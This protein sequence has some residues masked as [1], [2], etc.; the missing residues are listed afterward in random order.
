MSEPRPLA[1]RLARVAVRTL[2][3]L[4]APVQRVLAG[5]PVVVDGQTLDTQAQLGMRLL[6]L[7]V[8]ET[9]ERL[10][11]EQG[12][13]QISGEAWVFGCE[14]PVAEVR[15]TTLPGPAGP[16]PVR[17][18]RPAGLPATSA[19]LV[20]LHGG[21][22]VLGDLGSG[23]SVCRYLAGAAGLT[24]VSVDYRLAPEHP[25]PAALD[26][27]L[28]AFDAVHEGAADLGIDPAALGVGGES[29]GGNLAA[30][31]AIEA[32]RRA[33]ADASAAVPAL[34][35]LLMPVTDLTTK[36]RSYELFSDGYFLSA[37]QMDWYRAHYLADPAQ[38]A[39]PRVSPLLAPDLAGVAPAH[40]ATAGFDV[41]RDEGA[42][43][44][45]RLRAAGV[46]T[47]YRCHE[48][49]THG[50]VNATG[51]GTTARRVL[52]DVAAVLRRDLVPLAGRDERTR[53]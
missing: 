46:P 15:D 32:A 7:A 48:G 35:V 12:R 8:G 42:A 26:D 22:W 39:D 40:V 53:A 6:A 44:A 20:Y 18:Y 33:R 31:V 3:A 50:L 25:F 49:I 29:A 4:P 47:T 1:D 51:V 43:Y 52:D 28:A 2:G 14:H 13:R 34:Q 37:A 24:V 27:A 21:G 36:R 23:D 9:F 45:E 19:G 5:R 38:A 41:L 10:P 11:V 16:V 17:V 30:V